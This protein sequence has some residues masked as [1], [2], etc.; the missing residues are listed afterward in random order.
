[1]Q[2]ARAYFERAPF[3]Y[4]VAPN[5]MRTSFHGRTRGNRNFITDKF[6]IKYNRDNLAIKY[7]E[8]KA[9]H[10]PHFY[11]AKEMQVTFETPPMPP[12][13][14]NIDTGK[15]PLVFHFRTESSPLSVKQT[16]NSMDPPQVEET[17][18]LDE[19]H[20]VKHRVIK[21]IVQEIHEIILPF[22]KII[23]EIKP[24]Q[25]EVKTIVARASAKGQVSVQGDS[26]GKH[27]PAYQSSGN[28]VDRDA[29]LPK[30]SSYLSLT[31]KSLTEF[32]ALDKSFIE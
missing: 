15:V 4:R 1:M 29:H 6:V 11:T 27:S 31:G 22:R 26:K 14:I 9:N 16:H 3:P 18:S 7:G 28:H 2:T 20:F 30:A 13:I 24:V 21:P 25:E 32:D 17:K 12:Q 19:P 8:R 5:K 10:R 23:Q